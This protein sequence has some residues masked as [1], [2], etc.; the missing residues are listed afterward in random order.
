MMRAATLAC[1]L[2]IGVCPAMAEHPHG[3]RTALARE[4][5]P[6][7]GDHHFAI[8]T[9]SAEAQAYFDDGLRLLYGFNHDEAARYFR[10]AAVRGGLEGRNAAVEH[11]GPL[12]AHRRA[13]PQ[14]IRPLSH[15]MRDGLRRVDAAQPRAVR[16]AG[17]LG[18]QRFAGEPQ[19]PVER[20]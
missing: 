2:L 6:D 16:V 12:S 11:R 7:L 4:R 8:T 15:G 20:L 5:Y 10:R 19:P 3:E 9:R 1:G 14:S 17:E 18:V 13:G